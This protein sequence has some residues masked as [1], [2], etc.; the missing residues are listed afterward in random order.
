MF[1]KLMKNIQGYMPTRIHTT[2]LTCNKGRYLNQE[3]HYWTW[4]VPV[5]VD[6]IKLHCDDNDVIAQAKEHISHQR[7][8]HILWRYHFIQEIIDIINVNMYRI[9]TFDNLLDPLTKPH[10]YQK[11][12]E[13]TRYM[14]IICMLDWL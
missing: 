14:G 13:H 2:D 12:G 3:V 4:L 10:V 6:L 8:K 11:H 5:I 1:K 9:T 7:S